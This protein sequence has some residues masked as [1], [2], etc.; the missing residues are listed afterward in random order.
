MIRVEELTKTFGSKKQEKKVLDHV[1]WYAENGRVTGLFGKKASGKT[2][3]LRI[4]TGVQKPTSGRVF[5]NSTNI[6]EEP[7]LAKQLFG[8]VADSKEVFFGLTGTQFLN[9]VADI[10]D[11]TKEERSQ[12]M[13]DYLDLFGMRTHLGDKLQTLSPGRL[14]K[15]M[16]MGAMIHQPPN[17]IL[18]NPFDGL[19]EGDVNDI[20]SIMRQYAAKGRAVLFTCSNLK[21]AEHLCDLVIYMKDGRVKE[22]TTVEALREKYGINNA[23]EIVELDINGELKTLGS[24]D[25]GE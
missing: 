24:T 7:E 21:H 6:M 4:I 13:D 1:N 8:Y 18:D 12:F 9:F 5:L 14:K 15:V 10:Y 20:K 11:V 17:L 16:L 2:L 19:D 25:K 22:K 23:W 3:T